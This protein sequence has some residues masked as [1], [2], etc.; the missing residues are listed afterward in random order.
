MIAPKDPECY[1]SELTAIFK[2]TYVSID[3]IGSHMKKYCIKRKL[4]TQPLRTLITSFTEKKFI[5][6][7]TT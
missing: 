7:T 4:M 6:N 3:D 2:N 5:I 1:F